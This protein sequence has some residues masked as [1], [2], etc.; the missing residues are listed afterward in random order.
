MP[1]TPPKF[2]ILDRDGVINLDS[3]QFIK[4]PDE[5][6]PIPGS[7]EAIAALNQAGYRVLVASNQSGIGRGLFEMSTLNA[8]HEKMHKLLAGLGGRIDAV[9]FCPHTAADD[10]DCRKPRPGMLEQIS[11]RYGVELKGV[12]VVGDA[13]RD[14]QAGVAVGCSPHLVLTGKGRGTLDKGG[15][16]D[17]TRVHDDLQAFSRW[18]LAGA[19]KPA[20]AS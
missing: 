12:P 19:G 8:M 10:C 3:D 2:I 20:A 11:A 13:L 5:W 7:L 1:Q 4:S 9:F 16:P 18:L 14:L 6:I 15:L 17:G